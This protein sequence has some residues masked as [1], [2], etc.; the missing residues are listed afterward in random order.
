[1]KNLSVKEVAWVN[2]ARRTC[3]AARTFAL[4]LA[5]DVLAVNIDLQEKYPDL[6]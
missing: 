5:C 1:M 4:R 3:A 6:P 2:R